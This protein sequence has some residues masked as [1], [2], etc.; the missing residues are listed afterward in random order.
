MPVGILART[1]T[2]AELSNWQLYA[3]Q[4]QLPTQRM[5]L[6]LAQLCLVVATS[7][8]G[9][10]NLTLADFLLDFKEPGE[11]TAE[12]EAEFFDFKPRNRVGE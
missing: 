8:G 2:E 12:D 3:A 7:L 5:E 9:R 1:M 4:R 11:P 10:E 6:Y